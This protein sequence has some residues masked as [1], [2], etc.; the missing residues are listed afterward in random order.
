MTKE[1]RFLFEIWEQVRDVVPSARRTDV[2]TGIM[3]AF[4]E[5]GYDERDLADIVDEDPQLAKA[6]RDVFDVEVDDDTDG[7]SEDDE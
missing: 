1:C 2:A 4:A 6:Y 3:R 5:F 7:D